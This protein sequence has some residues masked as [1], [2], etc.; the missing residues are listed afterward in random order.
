MSNI[1]KFPYRV[2]GFDYMYLIYVAIFMFAHGGP[3]VLIRHSFFPFP[4]LSFFLAWLL[5]QEPPLPCKNPD[6]YVKNTGCH[7]RVCIPPFDYNIPSRQSITSITPIN[8]K[9]GSVDELRV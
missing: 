4:P 8:V 6:C 3:G 7:E 9:Y 1:Q 2:K 5:R